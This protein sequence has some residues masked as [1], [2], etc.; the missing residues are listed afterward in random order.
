V[1]PS[2]SRGALAAAILT[3]LVPILTGAQPSPY[4]I[5][6]RARAAWDA[7]TIPPYVSFRVDCALTFLSV[8][9]DPGARVEFVVRMSD[10]RTYAQ[11][12][13]SST[14]PPKVLMRGGFITGPAGMPLGFYRTLPDGSPS[15]AASPPPNLAPDP[16]QTIAVV[17][18]VNRVYDI[19]LD[20]EESIDG[21]ACYRLRMQPNVAGDRYPLRMLWVDE[22]TFEILQ[23]QYERP[24]G[25][26]HAMVRY[27]FSQVGPLR[28]W[29]IVR[30]EADAAVTTGGKTSVEQ[31][32]EVLD[33]VG[34]P[35]SVP[36]SYFE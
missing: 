26:A 36:G 17:T 24:Y 13:G 32:D 33:D 8:A 28:L 30:I 9:C 23:L 15:P 12:V 31:V 6:D 34:F 5:F 19:T 3:L 2:H 29:T 14:V 7:R 27:R 20:G 35:A 21:H 16:L 1:C 10:G 4:G 11:T 22:N 25:A 18:A